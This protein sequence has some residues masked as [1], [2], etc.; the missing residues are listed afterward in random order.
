MQMRIGRNGREQVH[1]GLWIDRDVYDQLDRLAQDKATTISELT[2]TLLENS[3][4]AEKNR[5]D[6]EQIVQTL[7]NLSE[8]EREA[9]RQQVGKHKL[10]PGASAQLKKRAIVALRKLK[11]QEKAATAGV[12]GESKGKSC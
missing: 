8:S 12:S 6:A 5:P 10:P 1:L 9:I 4:E 3:V 7:L 11:D 2:R